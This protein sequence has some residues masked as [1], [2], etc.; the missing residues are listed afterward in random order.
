MGSDL[1]KA[2]FLANIFY[3][4]PKL[5]YK[6][7]LKRSSAGQLMG[8]ILC[9]ELTYSEVAAMATKK[10]RFIPGLG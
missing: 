1:A 10:L 8:R 2:Q 9:G 6:L 4:A 7:G 5:A 3:K